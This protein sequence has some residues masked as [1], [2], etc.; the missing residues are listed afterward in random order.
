MVYLANDPRDD[1]GIEAV[2]I[3]PVDRGSGV[4]DIINRDRN[5]AMNRQ[6][7][8]TSVILTIVVLGANLGGIIWALNW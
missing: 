6:Q 5:T 8:V 7:I 1:R 3:C 4:G 2:V